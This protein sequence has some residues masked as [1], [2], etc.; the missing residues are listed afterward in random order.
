MLFRRF[1]VSMSHACLLLAAISLV[2]CSKSGFDSHF[3]SSEAASSLVNEAKNGMG[4]NPG[5]AQVVEE[6]FGTPQKLKVWKKLPLDSGGVTGTVEETAD[7]SIPVKSLKL[8]FDGDG[9]D[10][11]DGHA[12]LQVVSGPAAREVTTLQ[13][14]SPETG[15]GEIDPP[16]TAAPE[17]GDQ[18]VINGGATLKHGRVLYMRHCSHCHGT[19]GDGAGPTAEYLYPR[20]RDYRKGVFK[21]TSTPSLKEPARQDIH[22]IL[23]NGIPGTYMPS[24]VP[25]LGTDE[26]NAVVEYVR[27]L[28]MRGQFE[29]LLASPLA[30]D[31]S[32]E[33]YKDRLKGGETRQEILEE[34]SG[35]LSD[36]MSD[37]IEEAG[38]DIA[39]KWIAADDSEMTVVPSVPRVEDSVESR[40]RGRAL[41]VGAKLNCVNCHGITAKGN[42]PQTEDYELVEGKPRP[43]PGLHDVWGHLVKPRNLTTGIYRG[44]RRPID[45]FRR[46]YSGINGAKMPAFGGKI[47]DEQLWDVVN[48]VLSI[49]F[50]TEPGHIPAADDGAASVSASL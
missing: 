25:M 22:R 39:D 41:F 24:F 46:L 27:F 36:D 38:D 15:I 11:S 14:W 44:G 2:G 10:L 37:L 33:A 16:L 21:F 32:V 18:I 12:V 40:R 31:Y 28:A 48:Y 26:L 13:E 35:V 6:Q 49:P 3:V 30:I 1:L 19:S 4:D 23:Q 5:V 9:P 47:P 42:G 20:P 43:N 34:L 17:A 50:E 8:A 45:L 29:D 7:A